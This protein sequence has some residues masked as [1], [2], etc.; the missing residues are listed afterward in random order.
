MDTMEQ[1][2]N[3]IVDLINARGTVSFREL[4]AEFPQVSEMTLRTDLKALDVLR[5]RNGDE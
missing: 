1:R 5:Q 3:R 2:R 4:K